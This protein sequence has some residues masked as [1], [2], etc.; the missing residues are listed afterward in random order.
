MTQ[1]ERLGCAAL[2]SLALHGLAMSGAWLP[3]AQLP[4]EPRP[5]TARLVPVDVQPAARR[6]EPP[7][8]PPRAAPV[9]P[10]AAPVLPAPLAAAAEIPADTV[11]PEPA[12][13]RAAADPEP[14]QQIALA[15]ESSAVAARILPRRGRITYSLFYGDNRTY[16][17]KVI[18]S[19]EVEN[20]TYR[21]ASE[22]ETAGVVE[23]FRPQRLRYLS[24][25]II[26]REGLRP[27]SFLMRRT[28]RGQ[29]EAAQARFDWQGGS[30]AY[31]T[32]QAPKSA[33]LPAGSHDFMSFIY[34]HAILPPAAGR[35]RVSITSGSRFEVYDVEVAAEESIETP[36]G[37]LRA[38][39]VKQVPR[40]G[41]E[42][43]QIWLAS[44]YRYLPVRIRHFDRDGNFSG[45]QLA[46]EIRISEE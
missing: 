5:I 22:A 35:F 20:D 27:E 41:S 19:W 17:G 9:S 38:L 24:Q 26:T 3:L 25:G 4:G 34:Q 7:P 46:S 37:T 6:P 8:E 44:E 28:R 14:P 30:L 10:R 21:I 13:E 43:I 18:Q 31:G 45:E 23:V 36:L 12:A 15:P 32:A 40:P 2:V 16:V 42:S 11:P 29:T 39:P 33:P 1:R